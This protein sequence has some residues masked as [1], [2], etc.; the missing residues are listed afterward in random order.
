MRLGARFWFCTRH[1][2]GK[3]LSIAT[4][5]QKKYLVLSEVFSEHLL[6]CHDFAKITTTGRNNSLQLSY[7]RY[8]FFQK[9]PI[10]R[11][12]E[13]LLSHKVLFQS[14]NDISQFE[15]LEQ[16]L[17]RHHFFGYLKIDL[18]P[19]S[20]DLLKYSSGLE[21]TIFNVS[22]KKVRF[23]SKFMTDLQHISL[24]RHLKSPS[25][26]SDQLALLKNCEDSFLDFLSDAI[27]YIFQ[28]VVVG[29]KRKDVQKEKLQV[30]SIISSKYPLADRLLFFTSHKVVALLDV[31]NDPVLR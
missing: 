7:V 22:S 20:F 28:G 19:N 18:S 13:L 8:N 11:E 10:G 9:S 6:E 17:R 25:L 31:F 23:S 4:P 16:Q 12:R 27:V 26:D 21:P 2:F 24:L 1:R 14:P 5:N 3:K 30:N 15:K 29:I